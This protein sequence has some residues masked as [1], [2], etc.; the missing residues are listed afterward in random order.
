MAPKVESAH[1][2]SA[3]RAPTASSSSSSS[4]SSAYTAGV[5]R[6][7]AA[8]AVE[9][10]AAQ[11]GVSS[12]APRTPTAEKR[13]DVGSA[14]NTP[15]SS[16]PGHSRNRSLGDRLGSSMRRL[17]LGSGSSKPPTANQA[18]GAGSPAG[19]Q[20]AE[21]MGDIAAPGVPVDGA[22]G[23]GEEL[24]AVSAEAEAEALRQVAAAE[25][26]EASVAE[27]ADRSLK[28]EQALAV[29]ADMGFTD[30]AL[31]RD[32]VVQCGYDAQRAVAVLC[33]TEEPVVEE[34]EE[35]ATVVE[36]AEEEAT[37]VA[38]GLLALGSRDDGA[39]GMEQI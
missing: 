6:G 15:A 34:A 29:L 17:R 25:A 18:T 12:S 19:V 38:D 2:S 10:A 13:R 16:T 26:S 8:A 5:P 30:A 11:L 36:E 9:R 22:Y 14:P 23:A 39:D 4:S 21:A 28:L 37:V 32:I 31:N 33:G 1:P 35:E 7:S 27:A 24:D 3:A 20:C